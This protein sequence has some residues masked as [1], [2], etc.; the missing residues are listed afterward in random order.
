MKTR[1]L[2][3]ILAL[4]AVPAFASAAQKT[5]LDLGRRAL[6]D[7]RYADAVREL[8]AE[9]NLNTPRSDEALFL[10]GNALFYEKKYGEAMGAYDRLLK[11][12]GNSRWHRKA[13]F[14]KADCFVA[15]KQWDKAA[16]IYEP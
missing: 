2:L 12:R 14:R 5:P 11:E 15:L 3:L 13:L 6:M 4:L 7:R 1:S 8:T 16:E 9:A 10:L